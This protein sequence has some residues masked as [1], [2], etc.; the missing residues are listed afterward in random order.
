MA[1]QN[2]FNILVDLK[3]IRSIDLPLV[4]QND[5]V[6]FILEV[7]ENGVAFDLTNTTTV[8]LA[9]TRKDGSVVVTQGT[10]VG[11]KATFELGTNETSVPGGVTAKAQFYDA[12]GRVST[13]SFSYQVILDPTG[14]GYIPSASEQT[15]I[16]IVLNDGPLIIASAQE[17]AVY[18]NEQ[19]DYALQ[20]GT[21]NET[22]YLNAV[23]SVALRD[24]TY[25]IPS[26]GDTIRVTDIST[27]YRY[28]LGTGWVVTDVYNPTAIDNLNSQLASIVDQTKDKLSNE[29]AV[30]KIANGLDT[31]GVVKDH[32]PKLINGVVNAEIKG[33]VGGVGDVEILIRGKNLFD[34]SKIT[35]RL[36]INSTGAL[37]NNK[38]FNLTEFIYLKAGAYRVQGIPNS[39][40][41]SIY[42]FFVVH[43]L[44]KVFYSNVQ[45]P[46]TA[47]ATFTMPI[48]G[49][50]RTTVHDLDLNTFQLEKGTVTTTYEKG[51]T[52]RLT[53]TLGKYEDGTAFKL[54][55]ISSTV[56]DEITRTNNGYIRTQRIDKDGVTQLAKPLIALESELGFKVTGSLFAKK[57]YEVT[58]ISNIIPTT[59]LDYPL[60]YESRNVG[61]VEI[62]KEITEGLSDNK[63]LTETAN[64]V[65]PHYEKFALEETVT[66]HAGG[67]A[68]SGFSSG[69]QIK[70][71]EVYVVRNSPDHGTTT[72]L[73][74]T[75]VAYI[76]G[77]DGGFTTKILA[78]D[79]AQ[80]DFRDPN[81]TTE[82]SGERIMLKTTSYDLT[83]YKVWL[84]ILDEN[85]NVVGTP[86]LITTGFFGWG[87][88]LITPTG[89]IITCA[90]GM[91]LPGGSGV[92]LF[93]SSGNINAVGTFSNAAE[94]LPP[95]S[96]KIN[97]A[98]I[99]Y[100]GNKLVCISR[101]NTGNGY[102]ATTTDLEGVTGWTYA[103]TPFT[104]NAPAIEPYIPKNE[105]FIACI[106][107]FETNI[108]ARRPAFV[109]SVDLTNWTT[110]S[111][112]VPSVKA[113]SGYASFVRNRYGYG[114]QWYEESM[115]GVVGTTLY[116]ND[117]DIYRYIGNL[118]AL[119]YQMSILP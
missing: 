19:G 78:L 116:F 7:M 118:R 36:L 114:V 45:I 38:T 11:N 6:V 3:V 35:K 88:S 84:Y 81:I 1:M 62:V 89:K 99:A 23:S 86:T 12:N 79:Y 67:Y 77:N 117:V 63:K 100:W 53:A 109:A 32:N 27:S 57:D 9:H 10:K 119:E 92:Y 34:N 91:S 76:R 90:Y 40:M 30:Y 55:K 66:T 87:N 94:V 72:G 51:F 42:D 26:H 2:I 60:T 41:S 16:E 37:V 107:T 33:A 25:P 70:G 95:L 52:S 113:G 58:V 49:Y 48:D 111:Y 68:Y 24:S 115:S 18:A 98:T 80:G 101:S 104:I 13:L 85:L 96:D 17:A 71:K 97:E 39:I 14:S 105:P 21:D 22:R 65:A 47:P 112:L 31:N 43:D 83:T 4:T 28:V 103:R 15:L 64:N 110:P 93:K 56:F 75:L 50:L 54:N 5:S 102:I 69:A 73:K 46:T 108:N 74:S 8:S 44:N 59:T 29:L 82:K 61:I 106:S 20:V